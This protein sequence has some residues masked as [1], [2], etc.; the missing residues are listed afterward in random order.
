MSVNLNSAL[1]RVYQEIRKDLS[2]AFENVPRLWKAFGMEV[3]SS[4]RSTLQAWLSDLPA[5][6]EWL[7]AR[8]AKSM[9]TRTWS[10]VNR[11][12]EL[13]LE[14]NRYDIE[15]DL[16][17]VVASAQL[18]AAQM[19]EEFGYHEDAL[20]AS[21]L[22]AGLTATCFNGQTFFSTS[23]PIDPDNTAAGT[24]SNKLTTSPLSAA[25]FGVARTQFQKFKRENGMPMPG[26]Q[27]L[28]L[29]VPPALEVTARQIL[30][31]DY[32]VPS[33]S[34]GAIGSGG[35]SRNIF[36]SAADLQVN[37][38]LTSDT[39]WFLAAVGGS[40]RPMIFQRRQT[41]QITRKDA[42]TDENVVERNVYLYAADA[43]YNASYGLPHLMICADA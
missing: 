14:L 39:R 3:P 40:M 28:L 5:V 2:T 34:F 15:D 31:S 35:A 27:Q 21:T 37:P 8:Q 17:G 36:Q 7:G 10:I 29:I 9:G 23:H 1:N 24:F 13:S 25:N 6:R 16:D 11:A 33:S 42:S 18:R 43:R 30:Q 4:S 22:E 20:M 12:W 41:P 38:H 26:A 19:G 32:L